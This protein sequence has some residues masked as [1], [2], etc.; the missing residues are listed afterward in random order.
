M[1][2]K[3]N[4]QTVNFLVFLL[5][6]IGSDRA[7]CECMRRYASFVNCFLQNKSSSIYTS[8]PVD[9]YLSSG[10]SFEQLG[11]AY[12][13]LEVLNPKGSLIGL[14][15]YFYFY[16]ISIMMHHYVKYP[17]VSWP[18]TLTL[19]SWFG[20]FVTSENKSIHHLKTWLRYHKCLKSYQYM[21]NIHVVKS[22]VNNSQSSRT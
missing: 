18:L 4:L 5:E 10:Y 20:D 2:L 15:K 6:E 11:P 17:P 9:K 1:F 14:I 7:H 21:C 8:Y 22:R 16:S 3:I 12:Q 13:I 19:F